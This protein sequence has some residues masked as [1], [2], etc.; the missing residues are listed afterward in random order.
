MDFLIYLKVNNVYHARRKYL[1]DMFESLDKRRETFQSRYIKSVEDCDYC[2]EQDYTKFK[3]LLTKMLELETDF[4]EFYSNFNLVGF[5]SFI[6][7]T[8]NLKYR[9]KMRKTGKDLLHKWE[10]PEP[11]WK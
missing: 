6:K 1:L 10:I 2:A 7:F 11:G 8:F 9:L 4:E 5:K 3:I